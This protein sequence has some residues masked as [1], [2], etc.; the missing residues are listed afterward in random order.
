M[1]KSVDELVENLLKSDTELINWHW[2]EKVEKD[3]PAY[4]NCGKKFPTD[5][6]LHT[7]ALCKDSQ[8]HGKE[9]EKT[10]K[11]LFS[12]MISGNTFFDTKD[13]SVEFIKKAFGDISYPTDINIPRTKV[14]FLESTEHQNDEK[15]ID[16]NQILGENTKILQYH[17]RFADNPILKETSLDDLIGVRSHYQWN[18][19]DAECTNLRKEAFKWIGTG[20]NIKCAKGTNKHSKSTLKKL[21]AAGLE[22]G[23]W[24]PTAIDCAKCTVFYDETMKDNWIFVI[25][26]WEQ[27][28]KI[29]KCIRGV[30]FIKMTKKDHHTLWG[31]PD[32]DSSL[33]DEL[34]GQ[35]KEITNKISG[36]AKFNKESWKKAMHYYGCLSA[37]KKRM[38]SKWDNKWDDDAK[39]EKK[40]MPYIGCKPLLDVINKTLR[41]KTTGTKSIMGLTPK[42]QVDKPQNRIQCNMN[43]GNFLKWITVKMKA[44]EAVY[45]EDFNYLFKPVSSKERDLGSSTDKGADESTGADKSTGADES[46]S[47]GGKA[48]IQNENEA[49]QEEDEYFLYNDEYYHENTDFYFDDQG[50]PLPFDMN[51]FGLFSDYHI[52][53]DKKLLDEKEPEQDI[54][55]T[56]GDIIYQ[57]VVLSIAE[58]C[59]VSDKDFKNENKKTTLLVDGKTIP[60]LDYFDE[61]KRIAEWLKM[62]H[63]SN[64]YRVA[65]AAAEAQDFLGNC[66]RGRTRS[67]TASSIDHELAT[68]D[69]M[70]FRKATPEGKLRVINDVDIKEPPAVRR[71]SFTQ[72]DLAKHDIKQRTSIDITE[73]SQENLM[74]GQ[75]PRLA[76]QERFNDVGK[77]VSDEVSL[78]DVNIEALNVAGEGNEKVSSTSR[79]HLSIR[80]PLAI[81][82]SKSFE[83]PVVTEK[84]TLNE[85]LGLSPRRP[86]VRKRHDEDAPSTEGSA[87]SSQ[88]YIKHTKLVTGKIIKVLKSGMTDEEKLK[89][90][91]T[92][93]NDADVTADTYLMELTDSR[94]GTGTGSDSKSKDGS[95][96]TGSG[97]SGGRKK[98]K[99]RKKRTKKKRRR[100]KKTRYKR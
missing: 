76:S 29:I 61:Q 40:K 3:D 79:S 89:Q 14:F 10:L 77:W 82:R 52:D 47:G 35:L 75:S 12:T 57:K 32:E 1:D 87:R 18:Y 17:P 38:K 97:T 6:D 25:G 90:I 64:K 39:E 54:E 19:N 71:G 44:K 11:I 8:E 98:K 95:S 24:V 93:V 70:S 48:K 43:K 73:V 15:D 45:S 31:I 27:K 66:W 2:G 83:T 50:N 78:G 67:R 94:A 63:Q 26:V 65:T 22:P 59:I 55:T 5:R 68:I 46:K 41:S 34:R 69:E 74:T 7:I 9:F 91:E 21:T 13:T 81:R 4:E 23:T 84:R 88:R 92:E 30:Y 86:Q 20:M 49:E 51:E 53:E 99:R 80:K 37:C 28:D 58:K 62:S 42:V 100:K 16:T 60:K 96:D 36:L 33:K 56:D 85:T 72:S